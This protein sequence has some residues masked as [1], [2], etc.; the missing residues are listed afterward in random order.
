MA[1]NFSEYLETT[2][3]VEPLYQVEGKAPSCPPGFRW[4]LK[5]MRCIPKTSKDKVGPQDDSKD[6]KPGNGPSYNVIGRT[7]VNGD[8]YAYAEPNAWETA[9]S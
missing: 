3:G 1:L 2:D 6:S 4:D 5:T 9:D 8:G 7:G